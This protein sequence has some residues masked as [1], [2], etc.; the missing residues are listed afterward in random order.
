[1]SV[2]P[3]TDPFSAT[4]ARRAPSPLR[5]FNAAGVLSAADVHVALR[6]TGLAGSGAEPDVLLAAALAVR[7]PRMGHVFVDLARVARTAIVESGEELDLGTLPWP[8]PE[9]WPAQVAAAG[10]LVATSDGGEPA[11]AP[12]RPL[13]LIGTRLYLDRYWREERAV[14]ADLQTAG[15]APL[16]RV[17]VPL[18]GE[19][20]ARLFGGEDDQLQRVAAAC[21]VLRR[22]AVLAGGPGTGKT[23]TVARIVALI[24]EQA[25]AGGEQAPLVALAAPT[26]RAAA[27]LQQAVHDE[28]H[29]LDV[30]DGVRAW[31]L[32]LRASTIHRL[33]AYRPGSHSRFRHDR[34]NRLPHDVVI[35]DES[36]MVSL[37]LMA[38]LLEAVRPDARL[39]LVGDHEQL[40]AIEAGAVLRDIVGPTAG[41]PRMS[42]MTR[43]IVSRALACEVDAALVAGAGAFG[44]GIVVLDRVRRFGA[45]IA[46]VANAVRAGDGALLLSVLR[47]A[48]EEVTWIQPPAGGAR[49]P[50][51]SGWSA[52]LAPLREAAVHCGQA[53]IESSRAGDGA[54]ALAALGSFRLLCAQRHGPHGVSVWTAAIEGWLAAAVPGFDPDGTEYAGRPLLI[55]RNDDELRLYNGDTGVVIAGAPD[56]LAAAFERDG[57]I[58]TLAPSRLASVE[59]VYAM[60]IHKSQGSQFD[61]TAVVLGDPTSRILTRELLYTA[62]TRAR[63]KLILV[64][65]ATALQA[66]VQRPVARATGLR[67]RLWGPAPG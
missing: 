15:S 35:V 18:L 50:G 21:A 54:G 45:G 62:V 38:R 23:T 57:E 33:L 30:A 29:A 56:R 40:T 20:I 17:D 27:R 46:A 67:E 28:A 14:A 60:T 49:G 6:L 26:G 8:A 4:L 22:L 66:A 19:G 7:A 12:V 61:V 63:R 53:V 44:D 24:G 11:D 41:P 31:L 2:P 43:S 34:S 52:A 39:V 59:T 32:S 37:S 51:D 13:R 48:G 55:T 9:R 1:M 16:R 47:D 36:S 5:E 58:V 65:D 3:L 42:R 10:G 64:A 25:I